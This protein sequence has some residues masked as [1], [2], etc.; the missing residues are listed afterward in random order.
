[1]NLYRLLPHF[2]KKTV[3]SAVCWLIAWTCLALS[4]Y[5]LLNADSFCR[6]MLADI[7]K[8]ADTSAR[9]P[10][11][12]LD[13]LFESLA[14]DGNIFVR[15]R[16]FKPDIT[17]QAAFMTRVYFRGSYAAYPARVYV[18]KA[19]EIINNGRDIGR[20]NQDLDANLAKQLDISN[21]VLFEFDN[22]TGN[23]SSRIIRIPK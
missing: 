4:G 12:R 10:Y 13:V 15:F 8:P 6:R 20:V 22:R 7:V 21:E 23:L 2:E 16:D 19:G 5:S 1:M 3:Y 11:T 18:S 14:G 9:N 17:S